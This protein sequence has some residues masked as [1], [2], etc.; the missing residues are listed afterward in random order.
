VPA[1]LDQHRLCHGST[2][3]LHLQAAMRALKDEDFGIA[4]QFGNYRE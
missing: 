3:L 2:L 1:P 4:L